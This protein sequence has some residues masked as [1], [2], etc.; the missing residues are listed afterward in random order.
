[1]AAALTILNEPARHYA[2]ALATIHTKSLHKAF[3]MLVA[4]IAF[5][6]CTR[7]HHFGDSYVDIY[8][9]IICGASLPADVGDEVPPTQM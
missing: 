5:I 4:A 7:G 3:N 9:T 8:N 6:F 1:M 2:R